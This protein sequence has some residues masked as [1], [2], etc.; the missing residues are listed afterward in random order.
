M[1]HNPWILTPLWHLSRDIKLTKSVRQDSKSFMV[2]DRTVKLLDSYLKML[3][4]TMQ[5]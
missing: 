2:A 5:L 3:R 4:E 1:C